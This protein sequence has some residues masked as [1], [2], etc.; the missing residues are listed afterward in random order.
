[1]EEQPA[2]DA[3]LV[4]DVLDRQLVQGAGGEHLDAEFDELSAPRL[5]VQSHSLLGGHCH[6]V[7]RY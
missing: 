5:R 1:M 6:I 7:T 3:G 4:G 2:R